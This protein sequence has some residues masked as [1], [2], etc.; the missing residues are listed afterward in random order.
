[1]QQRYIIKRTIQ[2]VI[3]LW[4]VL[5]GLFLLFRL[6]PGDFTS[7]MM[8]RGAS[9]EAI[10]AFE[11]KWGLNDPLH[12]QYWSYLTNFLQGDVGTSLSSQQPVW[13]Y[14]KLK[15]FNSIILI[16][17]AIT[18][19]YILGGI[20]GTV[21]GTNRGSKR[22]EL[23]LIPVIFLGS[24]PSFF[25]A[26]VVVIIFAG[27]LNWFPTSGM[28]SFSETG[29]FST[30]AEVYTTKSFA[31]H[32]FLPFFTIVARY[33]Y[34]PV[35]IMRTSIV[36]VLGQDFTFYHR[37]TGISKFDRT[38]HLVRHASLPVV[39]L[40]PVSMTRAIGGLVLIEKVF[41]WPGIGNALVDSVLAR[42]FPVVQFVFFLVAA[43]VIVSNFLVDITYGIIDP[44]VSVEN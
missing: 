22:E 41:N 12:V 44:R 27:V 19:A 1:M 33:L 10:A 6:L 23:G 8:Y 40:Y 5:T 15:L 17:P 2:M 31:M 29:T 20:I 4:A 24:F 11:A 35:L 39:T 13:D 21:F 38:R 36:E 18:V 34:S 25:L 32:Y 37:I 3:L 43:F 42:D 9:E 16:A 26:I 7:M 28:Y 30:W 14:V